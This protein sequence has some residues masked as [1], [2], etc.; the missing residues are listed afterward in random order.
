M[1][2]MMHTNTDTTTRR[3]IAHVFKGERKPVFL[4]LNAQLVQ[5]AKAL[6]PDLT[7]SAI[8]ELA[9]YLLLSSTVQQAQD[10]DE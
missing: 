8:L 4:R 2:A 9:L 3:R 6:Y 1:V 10:T 7:L 5:Y